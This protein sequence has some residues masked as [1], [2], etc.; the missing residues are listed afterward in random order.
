MKN[1]AAPP[2]VDERK[3]IDAMMQLGCVLTWLKFGYHVNAECHHI[4]L[5]RKRL[6][7]TYTIPLSP[8]Y[9][10]GVTE[11]GFSQRDMRRDFGASLADGSK[12]FKESHGT[13]ELEL[14]LK[15]QHALELPDDLPTTKILPRRMAA[16][17]SH[18][19]LVSGTA[20][21]AKAGARGLPTDAAGDHRHPGRSS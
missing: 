14:W 5:A 13:T 20:Q 12:A 6:G 16:P 17:E 2:T 19:G 15:I 10:R 21:D 9:H 4:T 3:R 18:V 1:N 11:P 8:W 7:P